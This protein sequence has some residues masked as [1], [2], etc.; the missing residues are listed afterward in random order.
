MGIKKEYLRTVDDAGNIEA[1]QALT[2]AS[3]AVPVKSYGVT[4]I[5]STAGGTAGTHGYTMEAPRK[6]LVKSLVVSV[7]STREVAVALGGTVYGT[8]DTTA[9]FSTGAGN[10]RNLTLVGL[11]TGTWAVTAASTGIVFS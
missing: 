5:T 1:V 2:A 6:G 4:S 11:S 9:T 7:G 8:A 10:R 3:T